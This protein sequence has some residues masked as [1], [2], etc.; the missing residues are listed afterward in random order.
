MSETVDE[1]A[2]TY[3]RGQHSLRAYGRQF[4]RGDCGRCAA[5]RLMWERRRW[6]EDWSHFRISSSTLMDLLLNTQANP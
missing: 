3:W 6:W 4:Q 5:G 1:L 2:R